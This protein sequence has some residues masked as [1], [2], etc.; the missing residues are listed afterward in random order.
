MG[1]LGTVMQAAR[2]GLGAYREAMFN[3]DP[4]GS[5]AG[6]AKFKEWNRWDSRSTRYDLNWA[7]YQNNAYRDFHRFAVGWKTSQGLYKNIRHLYNPSYRLGEF[8]AGHLMAGLLDGDAGDGESVP[9]ALPILTENQSIRP[10]LGNLWRDSNWAVKKETFTRWGSVLGDVALKV[11]DDL[12][13][14]Q[15]R[16]EVVHP[17]DLKHVEYDPLGNVKA[18]LLE[19]WEFD[20]RQGSVAV[21]DPSVNV[22]DHQLSVLYQEKAFRDGDDVVYQTFLNGKLYAWDGIQAEWHEPY[23]FIPLVIVHHESIGMDWGMNAWHA[24]Q[25]SSFTEVDDMASGLSDQIR[26]AIRAPMLIS[27]VKGAKELI[28]A[29]RNRS[30]EAPLES[31]G[32]PE[33]G[34]T[35]QN[36]L[37]GPI[38]AKAQHL[39]FDLKVSEVC[40]HIRDLLTGIEKNFPELLADTGNFGGTVTAEA[41]RWSRQQ[42]SSKVQAR[43]IAYDSGL[44]RAQKM[45][46]AIGGFRG[47]RDF[48]SFDLDSYAAGKLDHS[49]GQRPVFEVDP[50]DAIE[51]DQAFWT[52]AGLATK[53]GIPLA[54]YLERNGWSKEDIKALADAKAAEPLP[55]PVVVASPSQ[56]PPQVKP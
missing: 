31:A 43:R 30:R 6:L 9:S 20:P 41:I 4:Q 25:G 1:Y 22:A 45:A 10:A 49:I 48:E 38:D 12:L 40:E 42:S 47:Y 13:R 36:Y 50:K 26:K 54:L 56:T 16:L 29:G 7:Q 11:T 35:E 23:G 46:L 24:G 28:A 33:P 3:A 53:A 21:M 18:Y 14:G 32:D 51:E 37:Y 44:V 17:G 2:V 39:T 8:W 5:R 52:A 15:V 55:P 34:R 27:G 19:R